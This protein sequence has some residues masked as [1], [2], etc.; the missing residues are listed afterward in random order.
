MLRAGKTRARETIDGSTTR[1]MLYEPASFPRL[2]SLPEAKCGYVVVEQNMHSLATPQSAILACLWMRRRC[3]PGDSLTG[4]VDSSS[5][6]D[7]QMLRIGAE[8]ASHLRRAALSEA[9]ARRFV[10]RCRARNDA[11]VE[12]TCCCP[13]LAYMVGPEDE[14]P[15]VTRRQRDGIKEN[16]F[17]KPNPQNKVDTGC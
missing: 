6:C 14:R 4:R 2:S 10:P 7:Q 13:G 16:F 3:L 15:S 11:G 9:A 8:W 5:D 12:S 1:V 17:N